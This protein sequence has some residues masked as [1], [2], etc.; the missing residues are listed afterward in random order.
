MIKF[1]VGLTLAGEP[2]A[3]LKRTG[4][5]PVK[6]SLW[7]DLKGLGFAGLEKLEGRA[8]LDDGSV[9]ILNDNDFGPAGGSTP[10]PGASPNVPILSPP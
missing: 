8:I 3:E 7:L 9:A 5:N 6:R 1:T 10:I 2:E 4:V